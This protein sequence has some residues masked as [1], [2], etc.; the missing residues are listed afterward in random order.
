MTTQEAEALIERTVERVLAKRPM[1]VTVTTD[2]AAELLGVSRRTIERMKPPRAAGSRIPY[3]WVLER[4]A[5]R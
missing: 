1:P 3:A 4:L 5:S 2:M